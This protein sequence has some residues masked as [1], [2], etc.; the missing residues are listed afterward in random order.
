MIAADFCGYGLIH[1][2]TGIVTMVSMYP[3]VW[4]ICT[5]G[6]QTP[7]VA[8]VAYLSIY[9]FVL[10]AIA[11]VISVCRTNWVEVEKQLAIH[12]VDHDGRRQEWRTLPPDDL[13]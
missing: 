8:T 10:V 11:S 3:V 12:A 9:L 7:G 5:P 4:R 13:A 6:T 2:R 1:V